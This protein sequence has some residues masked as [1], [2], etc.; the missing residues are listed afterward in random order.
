MIQLSLR[1]SP[2]TIFK[3]AMSEK[4]TDRKH[5]VI[6]QNKKA[7]H[8]F[9]VISTIETG[10]V[11]TGTEVKSLR[12]GSC[13]LQDSYALFPSKNSNTL[14]LIGAHIS[15]YDFGN[16]ENHE[17]RR[18]RTLLLHEREL[19]KLKQAVQ[20]KGYTLVPLS[21]YFSGPY[22]K[23]ELAIVRGKKLYDKREDSKRKD[24]ERDLRRGDFS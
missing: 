12:N 21:L 7:R 6:A 1:H 17:P 23:V 2:L 16:R 11:L 18:E 13:N 3:V 14:K 19:N 9:E 4:P 22:V 20:E 8:D 15:P 5:K 10:I 24:I